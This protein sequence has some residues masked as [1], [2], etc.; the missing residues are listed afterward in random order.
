MAGVEDIY[1]LTPMQS[2]MLLHTEAVSQGTL[3]SQVEYELEGTVDVPAFEAAWRQGIRC[4]G[5]LRT[6]FL[7]RGLPRP[8][9]VV[10][11]DVPFELLLDDLSTLAEEAQERELDLLRASDR[12]PFDLDEPPL[13]RVRLVRL[14]AARHLLV[15]TVHHLIMDRWS[16]GVL[17]EDVRRHYRGEASREP[18]PAPRFRSFVDWVLGQDPVRAKQHWGPRLRNAPA[19]RVFG[20]SPRSTK[21]KRRSWHHRMTTEETRRLRGL[22]EDSRSTLAPLVLCGISTAAARISGRRDVMLGLTSAGRSADLPHADRIIGSLVGNVPFRL[23][24]P[25]GETLGDLV[26]QIRAGLLDQRFDHLSPSDLHM[27]TGLPPGSAPFDLLVVMNLDELAPSDW[28]TFI[29]HPSAGSLDSGYPGVLSVTLEDRQLSLELVCDEDLD[30]GSVLAQVA[31]SIAALTALDGSGNVESLLEGVPLPE[32]S[33]TSAVDLGRVRE[34]LLDLDGV[35]DAVVLDAPEL[36]AYLVPTREADLRVGKIRRTLSHR[37]PHG[38][39]PASINFLMSLPRN[40]D[41][42]VNRVALPPPAPPAY[43][44]GLVPPSTEDEALVHRVWSQVLDI[45]ELSVDEDFFHIGG[46][47]IQ[48]LQIASA[49]EDRLGTPVPATA[50]RRHTTVRRL[51]RHLGES[52]REGGEDEESLVPIRSKGSRTPLFL[53]HGRD[54]GV[55][56]ARFVAQYLHPD[57]PVFG[58]QAFGGGLGEMTEISIE[59][60]ASRYLEDVRRSTTGPILL[61][62]YSLGGVIA[63]EMARQASALGQPV[64]LL[65]LLEPLLSEEPLATPGQGLR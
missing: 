10:R 24:L 4:H 32:T 49:L 1:L 14:G 60:L 55:L 19:T 59:E 54:G 34:A 40:E 26:E 6:G 20:P 25:A 61:G 35:Q 36:A 39:T 57:R 33:E 53:V 37:L 21:G 50:L 11:A 48:M 58:I 45:D 5:A 15:W 31:R 29:M 3:V 51:A 9:Q 47:S 18:N 30:G 42:S 43:D 64:E 65:I 13:M 8:V 52:R 22:A 41:G 17:L 7:S 44:P 27:L 28:G 16:Q 38:W 56:F 46:T 23:N 2:L 12:R 63:F 62:G